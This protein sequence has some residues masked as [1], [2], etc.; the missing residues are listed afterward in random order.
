MSGINKNI[1]PDIDD[2]KKIGKMAHL[3][4]DIFWLISQNPNAIYDLSDEQLAGLI[5]ICNERIAEYDRKIDRLD[6]KIESL[7]RE[8]DDK[9]GIIPPTEKERLKELNEKTELRSR[10][11][12]PDLV[13]EALSK[14]TEACIIEEEYDMKKTRHDFLLSR[15]GMEN[16]R[17]NSG[18]TR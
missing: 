6:G 4:G 10:K 2:I 16:G 8:L 15:L 13:E 14:F 1:N 11:E 5:Q 3:K 18:M 17:K 12:E 7:E 9:N